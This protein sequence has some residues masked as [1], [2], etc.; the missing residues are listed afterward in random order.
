MA[1]G[2]FIIETFIK[3]LRG[4]AFER[5][6]PSTLYH[7]GKDGFCQVTTA[8]LADAKLLPRFF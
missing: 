7:K 6:L 2:C 5:V 4:T 8:F 1:L 3:N